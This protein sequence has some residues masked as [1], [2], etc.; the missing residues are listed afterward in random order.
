MTGNEY[1]LNR[2]ETLER[3]VKELQQQIQ[4]PQPCRHEYEV[5]GGRNTN[6]R[7]FYNGSNAYHQCVKCGH[8]K[9]C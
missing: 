7:T 1:L 2:L 3:Q 6:Y 9:R 5:V 4:K 8:R